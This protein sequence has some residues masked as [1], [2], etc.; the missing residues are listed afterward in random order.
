MIADNQGATSHTDADLVALVDKLTLEQKIRL[1]SGASI[2]SLHG[3]PTIGLRSIVMSD[4]PSG[5]RGLSLDDRDPSASLPSAT[6]VAATWDLDKVRRLGELI[7]AQARAKGVDVVLGPTV[8][9]HR[10]P[11]GG[12]H[13]ESFSE[14]PWLSGVLGTAYVQGVQSGGVAATPKHYVCND[15]ETDRMTVDV[16]VD[17]RTLREVY[18]AP[19]E[20]MVTEGNAWL[21]MSAYNQVNGTTMSANPLLRDPLKGEWGFDGVVVSDWT[22]VRDT[23]ASGASGQDIA[24]PGPEL[25]WGKALLDAV[26]SGHVSQAAI[27]DK[28]LRLL[29]LARR[30]GALGEDA[31]LQPDVWHEAEV[32]ALLRD[33]AVDAMVLVR[34]DGLLPMPESSAPR[35][36]VVGPHAR[37]GRNQGGGSATVFPATV[38]SPLDGLRAAYGADNVRYA[39]GLVPE[40]EL[41]PFGRDA[42]T[43]PATGQKGLRVRYL[44]AIG[45]VF[46]E[47]VFPTGQ[48]GWLGDTRLVRA[49]AIE[50][51]TRY[52]PDTTGRHRLGFTALGRIAFSVDGQQ[53][54]AGEQSAP[55]GDLVELI[56][57]PPMRVFDLE[58]EA[59]RAVDVTLEFH[60]ELPAGFPIAQLTL[61]T[62]EL[63]GTPADELDQAVRLAA[64]SDVAIVVVGTTEKIESEGFDRSTL[65]LPPGQ[66]ELINQVLAAN[67]RTAV[68]VNSGAPVLMPW[69]DRVP[70]VLLTWFPGQEFG[71][72]LA[73]VFTGAREPG[74]RIPTTWPAAQ[75]DV[76]VWQTEPADGHL[77]YAEGIHVGYR[78]WL[79]QAARGGPDPAIPFGH[80]LG[81]TTW[82]IGTPHVT[83]AT[84]D[85]T[86][87]VSAEITNTGPRAGKHVV[88]AYLSRTSPSDVDRPV[89]W[90]AG[91]ALV[92]AAPG[93]TV[94]VDIPI[95]PRSLQHWST[96]LH[97]WSHEPGTFEVRLG[98]N[99][100]DL[101]SAAEIPDK[102]TANKDNSA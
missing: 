36:A 85:G 20:R 31:A 41:H 51:S 76:P 91:Y 16:R 57:R 30:V 63:Y 78:A 86:I 97:Q 34:N 6:A 47:E 21:V 14:D 9:L 93:Q 71:V 77:D 39:P 29:R 62:E 84:D 68:V 59:G 38:I 99:V 3:E 18:L 23:E 45:A 80:G 2:W 88:Q 52:T 26:E 69:L 37:R 28:V 55:D 53:L 87:R 48:F 74:G 79:R 60:P 42:V 102:S 15:S 35:I 17:E 64:D 50:V 12:R 96:A 67:P 92:H 32:R 101:G 5:V 65:T 43:D 95:E 33:V 66:D 81:Y 22:A 75:S 44:D 89:R 83:E 58:L 11:R 40:P 24:M 98:S 70:A 94:T 13:F 27:D 4:G 10:S 90:L 19:F 49:A 8:N 25:Y 7:A 54:C 100:L 61:G 82:N 73:D 56:M 72:A 1:L 46:D